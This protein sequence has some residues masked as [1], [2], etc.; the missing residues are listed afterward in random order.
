VGAHYEL[1]Q[2]LADDPLPAQPAGPGTGPPAD[3]S[4]LGGTGPGGDLTPTPPDDTPGPASGPVLVRRGTLIARGAP[5][6]RNNLIV[7]R[8]GPSWIVRDRL[9]PLRAGAGC[10][11]L[12]AR[13][14][15]CRA[16]VK[17]IVL[18]GGA[19]NDRLTVIGRIPVI[20]R[21]GPGRDLARQRPR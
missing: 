7:R 15:S 4:P 20:F 16:R 18:Y 17:R 8:R 3:E 19:G 5:G 1:A 2:D 9:A 11:R 10:R 6:V 21:G 14:V 12:S 13:R